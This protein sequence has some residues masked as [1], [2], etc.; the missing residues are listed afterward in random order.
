[1]S[2]TTQYNVIVVGGGLVGSLCALFMAKRGYQVSLYEYREDPRAT[3][4]A[5]GR[6]INLALSNRAR[7]ALQEV[8]IEERILKCGIAMKGRYI[9]NINGKNKSILY[10]PRTRQCIYSVSRNYLNQE[11][12]QEVERHLNVRT[13]FNHKLINVDVDQGRLVFLQT[14]NNTTIETYGDLLIGADGAFSTV[15]RALQQTPL[16]NFSQT[17]IDHGYIEMNINSQSGRAM[18]PNHLHIWPRGEFMMIALPNLDYSWTVTLFMPFE[19]FKELNSPDK[20]LDFFKK[21]FPDSVE[22]LGKRQLVEDF[23]NTKPSPLVSI[24]CG[25]YHV[26]ENI[27]I[28]GDAAHAMVPFYGQG[29]NAGFEDCLLLDSILEDC[30][31][32]FPVALKLFTESRREDAHAICDLAMYNYMEMRDLVTR[33]SYLIRKKFDDFLFWLLPT[34]WIPLYNSV[35]FSE[36][37]YQRCISNRKW[38]DKV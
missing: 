34:T 4:F 20:V 23:A 19:R 24:K 26:G 25:S 29:M 32:N 11:L 16:F 27:L 21:F 18:V 38:Q 12:L 33:P 28:I 36:M 14:K 10:D 30:N 5:R 17:Y 31:D 3:E 15:R 6:S 22:L 8:G 7:R 9:H 37:N 2:T 13:Y 35:T 1:M